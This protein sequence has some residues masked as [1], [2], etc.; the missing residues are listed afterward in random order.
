MLGALKLRTQLEKIEVE[1]RQ[2]LLNWK[3]L[4]ES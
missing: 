4:P 3:T 1:I 2:I